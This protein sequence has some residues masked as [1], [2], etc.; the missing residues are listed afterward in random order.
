MG[1]SCIYTPH[2]AGLRGLEPAL[3]AAETRLTTLGLRLWRFGFADS[4]TPYP[5]NLLWAASLG[6]RLGQ[7]SDVLDPRQPPSMLVET[8]IQSCNLAVEGLQHTEPGV[9]AG[10]PTLNGC[11][12]PRKSVTSDCNRSSLASMRRS[13]ASV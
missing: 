1:R 13:S 7:H 10:Q 6:V 4:G 9:E 3:D 12:R 8:T 11:S 2:P 5:I